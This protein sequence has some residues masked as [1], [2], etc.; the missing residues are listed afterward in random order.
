MT[1][2][3]DSHTGAKVGERYDAEHA[4]RLD[5]LIWDAF[6]KPFVRQQLGQAAAAGATCYL[7]FACGTG[8]LLKVGHSVFHSS[9]GIDISQDMLA[10]ATQ[11][12]PDAALL[13]VDVT[14]DPPADMGPFDCVTMF[15]FVLNAESELRQQA[16][17]WVAAHMSEGGILIVNNHRNSASVSG[18]LS[19]MA[20]WQPTGARNVMSRR[21]MFKM[22]ENAGFAVVRCEGFRVLPSVWGR[23]VVGARLQLIGERLCRTLGL[24]RFGSELVV[25]AR[26]VRD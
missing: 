18:L 10:V 4:V 7:D 5:A 1:S 21:H 17:S 19:R 6:V 11:R 9:L 8:R 3:R 22:L 20:A 16:L 13:R 23:P 26:R 2:Y 25:V 24:S 12:V 15:R 14:R